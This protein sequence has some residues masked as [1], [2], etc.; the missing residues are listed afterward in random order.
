[1]T[2]YPVGPEALDDGA[3]GPF[4]EWNDAYAAAMRGVYER[5][6]DD[7]DVATLFA[8]ALI[9]RTPWQLWDI[10]AGVAAPGADT[11]EAVVVLAKAIA[12]REAA[13]LPPHP[14]RLRMPLHV[15]E[16]SPHPDRALRAC[17]ALRDLVPD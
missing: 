4:A 15:K 1:E 3:N 2:R 14:G 17:D 16:M 8:E 12:A 7:P 5:F 9:N 10:A 11:H 6:P 13:A